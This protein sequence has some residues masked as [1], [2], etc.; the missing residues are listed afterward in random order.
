MI[1]VNQKNISVFSHKLN[2]QLQRYFIFQFVFVMKIYGDDSIHAKLTD[3]CNSGTSQIFTQNHTEGGG[4]GRIFE[5]LGCK[6]NTAV[7]IV[8]IDHQF[9]TTAGGTM[10]MQNKHVFIRLLNFINP[11]IG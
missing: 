1:G 4:N 2:N 9:H 7:F 10:K 5:H 3:T 6:L 11:G 8:D